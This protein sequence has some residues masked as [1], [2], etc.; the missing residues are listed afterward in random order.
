MACNAFI[1]T[2]RLAKSIFVAFICVMTLSLSACVTVTDSSKPKVDKRKLLESNI[3]LGMAYLNQGHRDNALRSFTKA[4]ELD[5]SSA[6]AH[7]GMALIH[8]VNGE[9]DMADKRFQKALKSRADFSKSNIQFSYA[10]FLM[11]KDDYEGAF[12]LFEITSNDLSYGRRVNALFNLGLCAEKLGNPARAVAAYEHAL[13]INKN[14]APAAL[15][16]AH[17]NFGDENYAEAKKYLDV[18]ARNSRQSARSL[19]LGIRIERIFE[20]QDKEASYALALK[21]LHPYSREFLE[22]KKLQEADK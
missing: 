10:R 7:L 9:W 6:E 12:K 17:K 21:N 11:D 1:G 16:L 3:K 18:F 4:L 20:N 13:N 22:Y 2:K 15:E 5:K 8:Q 14:F 19:W